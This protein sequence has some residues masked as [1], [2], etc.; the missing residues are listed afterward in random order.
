[1]QGRVWNIVDEKNGHRRKLWEEKVNRK[2][3]GGMGNEERRGRIQ[4]ED[5]F[6]CIA[7][8]D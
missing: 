6:L 3:K 5:F 2:K 4:E 7:Q 1:L 8:P